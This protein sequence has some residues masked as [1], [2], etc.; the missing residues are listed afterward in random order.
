MHNQESLLPQPNLRR[1]IATLFLNLRTSP[2]SQQTESKNTNKFREHY[3][4]QIEKSIKE[5]G[6]VVHKLNDYLILSLFKSRFE[7]NVELKAIK[8]ALRIKDI[9]ETYNKNYERKITFGIG[10]HAGTIISEEENAIKYSKI[11]NIT[12]TARKLSNIAEND[13]I[14]SNSVLLKTGSSI[15]VKEVNYIDIDGK[16]ERIYTILGKIT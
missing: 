10:I 1:E 9:L 16:K 5:N 14:V 2:T 6:G 7:E 11:A 13:I 8:T 12:S 15:R 3:L 4:D